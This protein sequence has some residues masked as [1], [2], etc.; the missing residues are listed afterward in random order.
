MNNSN[1][2]NYQ[3][4]E[5][6]TCDDIITVTLNRP[7]KKNAMNFKMVNELITVAKVISKDR[8]A[9]AVILTGKGESFCSGL[10]LGDLN[11][12]KN[13]AFA[14]WELIKPWQ[15]EFQRVCLIWRDL[16]MPVIV[17]MKGYCF[18]AG[19]QLALGADIRVSTSDCQIAIMEAKWGLV[20]DMGLTQS[21][22]GVLRA[23]VAK[24][25][26]MS[27]RVIDGDEA[28]KLGLVSHVQVEPLTYAQHL[29]KELAQRSPDAVLASKRIINSMYAQSSLTLY[30]EK[31]WQ[32]KLMLGDNR[33]KALKKA[34][35]ATVQYA[36]RQFR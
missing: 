25:L 33:K 16:P 24:E 28:H 18:G 36:R 8:A 20:P 9:R 34:K 30:Q 17:A 21:A 11:N 5:V 35:D 1:I 23:D 6:T 12:P 26:A 3:T 29:A 14:L 7:D 22:L 32:L 10:D 31:Y 19:L 2:G 27:A 13:Q 15:S 4:L